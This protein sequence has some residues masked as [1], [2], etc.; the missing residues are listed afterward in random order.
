MEWADWLSLTNTAQ[1][2]R[3]SPTTPT[4]L[5][6]L[7]A[8]EST[9][10]KVMHYTVAPGE[11][12]KC[13]Q[14]KADIEDFMTAN[15]YDRGSVIVAFGGGVVG[16]LGGFVAATYMR[17]IK[18]V[19]VPTTLLAM[20]D[21]S[22]GGTCQAPVMPLVLPFPDIGTARAHT[23]SYLLNPPHTF[24]FSL[25]PT[26]HTCPPA[27]SPSTPDLQARPVSIFRQER[28]SS[29]RSTTRCVSTPT[30]HSSEH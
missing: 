12:S 14:T 16:D 21:S 24:S 22:I 23:H 19:Q 20:V 25:T 18:F 7:Q 8:G 3:F 15:G 29:G 27:T 28:I 30:F 1:T 4:S 26:N 17:G 13:R 6:C 5:A 9:P 2:H 11:Q 10:A